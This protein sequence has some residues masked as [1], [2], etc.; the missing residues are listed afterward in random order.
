MKRFY[1]LTDYISNKESF[2]IIKQNGRMIEE[3]NI[4][5]VENIYFVIQKNILENK[6]GDYYCVEISE[7]EYFEILRYIEIKGY[8]SSNFEIRNHLTSYEFS[9]IITKYDIN[10]ISRTEVSSRNSKGS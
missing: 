5:S 3:I 10:A 7:D 8:V 2:I 4:Q 6:K 1:V 9:R